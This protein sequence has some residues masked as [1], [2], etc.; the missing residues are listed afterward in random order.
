MKERKKKLQQDF[1]AQHRQAREAKIIVTAS[2]HYTSQKLALEISSVAAFTFFI[3]RD[4]VYSVGNWPLCLY[5]ISLCI[6]PNTQVLL[7]HKF[8]VRMLIICMTAIHT[9]IS[10]AKYTHILACF[11][12]DI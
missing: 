7:L 11:T 1:R 8:N 5:Y 9:F 12:N 10:F 3:I 6:I 4:F 2:A